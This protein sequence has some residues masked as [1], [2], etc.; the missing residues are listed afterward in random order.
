VWRTA[1]GDVIG[2]AG[3]NG[4][5]GGEPLLV[6]VM[7]RGRRL[8]DGAIA[9][10]AE[11]FAADLG[12]LPEGRRSLRAQPYSPEETPALRRLADE[13]AERIKARELG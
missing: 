6:E 12:A 11:R 7:D 9:A 4:P 10:A 5:D 13:V 2:R 8:D 1:D 3:E